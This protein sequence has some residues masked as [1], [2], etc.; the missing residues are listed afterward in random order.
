MA[1][2]VSYRERMLRGLMH[3]EQYMDRGISRIEL[4]DLAYFFPFH[5]HRIFRGM[6]GESVTSYIR[7]LRLERAAQRLM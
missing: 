6:V 3:I 1:D 7:Q 4:A 5:F 2:L